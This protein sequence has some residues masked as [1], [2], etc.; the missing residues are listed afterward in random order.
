MGLYFDN[1]RETPAEQCR[2]T[3]GAVFKSGPALNNPE[4]GWLRS[5]VQFP[6]EQGCIQGLL[7]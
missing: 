4:G 1:P 6:P 5:G 2:A 3:I 7:H